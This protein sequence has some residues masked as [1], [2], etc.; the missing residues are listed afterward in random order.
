MTENNTRMH[1]TY[2]SSTVISVARCLPGHRVRPPFAGS[3]LLTPRRIPAHFEVLGLPVKPQ[4]T[5][6]P[7]DIDVPEIGF[8]L[9]S[10]SWFRLLAGFPKETP[11]GRHFDFRD[12]KCVDLRF[13]QKTQLT[14]TGRVDQTGATWEKKDFT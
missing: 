10:T 11:P 4:N 9:D 13:E 7:R 1:G 12:R 8:F 2:R 6:Q 5:R 14:H 3:D